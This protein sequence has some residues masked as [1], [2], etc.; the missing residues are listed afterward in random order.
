MSC[1]S[2]LRIA[3]S[4]A[5]AGPF[6]DRSAAVAARISWSEIAKRSARG[7]EAVAFMGRNISTDR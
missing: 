6:R 3:A 1:S 7:F 5:A 2:R 4:S